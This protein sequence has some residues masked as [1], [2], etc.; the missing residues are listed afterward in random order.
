[1]RLPRP[2]GQFA[3]VR[4]AQAP[5]PVSWL[6]TAG[7]QGRLVCGGRHSRSQQGRRAVLSPPPQPQVPRPHEGQDSAETVP[8]SSPA[9]PRPG[10]PSSQ[11]ER[12]PFCLRPPVLRPH[13]ALCMS[14]SALPSWALGTVPRSPAVSLPAGC[15][16]GES[17]RPLPL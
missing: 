10:R 4:R 6:K 8:Q 7:A 14:I 1:M 5:K 2:G 12:A 16:R 17:E 15:L 9:P 11:T 13:Q 3:K